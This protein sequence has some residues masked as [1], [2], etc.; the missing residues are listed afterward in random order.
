MNKSWIERLLARPYF[1]YSFLA[2]FLL[3]GIQGY[4]KMERKLFPDSQY[5]E[6]AVV[7]VQPGGSAKTIAANI[8]VPIE[9]ELY[10]LDQ[11]RRVHSS[12]I[13]EVSVIRA[14]FEYSKNLEM[15]ASDVTTAIGKIR[16]SL[17]NDILEPQ[18]HKIS[19][20]TAPILVIAVSTKEQA[21]VSRMPLED[22]RQL[23]D[24][25]IKH[26]IIKL[27]GVANVDVFG[28]YDKE[29]QIILDKNKLDQYQMN[30]AQVLAV[31][32]ANNRK[33]YCRATKI[34]YYS[35]C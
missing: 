30:I 1:I 7:V 23:A 9:E 28:G 13:D 32:Q 29:V 34:K 22:I 4:N 25:Q 24:N 10:T 8:A 5:P 20:A 19:S 14:E 6:I 26:R 11:I 12:T 35:R 27:P 33:Q 15:A 18:I 16:S 3:L 31:L 17:P 21:I 2:L